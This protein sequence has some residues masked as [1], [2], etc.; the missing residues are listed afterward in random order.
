MAAKR[1]DSSPLS[2]WL[3]NWLP[4]LPLL[5][6]AYGLLVLPMVFL[7]G[8][9]LL[10][11]NGSLTLAHWIAALSSP[12]NQQA[13]LSSLLLGI[14]TATLALV[15]GSPI[16]WL[17]VR[18]A[19]LPRSL[20]LGGINTASHF[21]GI[22][23]AFGFVALLGTYGMVTLAFQ[24]LDLRF[25]PPTPG[26]FWGLA[27]AYSYLNIPLFILL[28]LPGMGGVQQE[29]WEAAQTAGATHWQFWQR[30]GLP[31]LTP[32]LVIGWTLIFTG[33]IGLYGLPFALG[34]GAP[35][36]LRLLPVQIGRAL[37]TS[38]AGRGEAA[39]LAL[40]LLLF[41]TLAL[42]I[43]RVLLQRIGRWR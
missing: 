22:G 35:Q 25:M 37:E 14:V 1:L 2:A 24:Q 40:L 34:V 10:A 21:S 12:M 31:L 38:I 7:L 43:S 18:M 6:I 36:S 5:A 20:W 29:W 33:S 42:G 41:T 23:L 30:I 8:Q 26:S 19:P 16:A 4:A 39:V 27:I 32:S 9:S 17:M 11:E 13:I 3:T 15:V 28:T